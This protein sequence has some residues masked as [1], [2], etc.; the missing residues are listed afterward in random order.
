M[1]K[2][3]Q[4]LGAVAVSA[5]L[6]GCTNSGLIT[7]PTYSR[8]S[9]E[10]STPE[11][12]KEMGLGKVTNRDAKYTLER[13]VIGGEEYDVNKNAFAQGRELPFYMIRKQDSHI[14]LN[15]AGK[16]TTS[17]AEFM[18]IPKQVVVNGLPAHTA[19]FRTDGPYGIK[20]SLTDHK[21]KEVGVGLIR[22]TEKDIQFKIKVVKIN[23]E[24]WYLPQAPA[25]EE[26]DQNALPFYMIPVQG[27]TVDIA[28]A[29]GAVTLISSRGIFHPE[30]VTSEQYNTLKATILEARIEEEQR[31]KRERKR[32]EA[33]VEQQRQALLE[34]LPRKDN[35]GVIELI[36]N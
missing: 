16:T 3:T 18:Y 28:R 26:K 31:E 15:E 22:E 24:E 6:V 21:S 23:G 4:L 10:Y 25:R 27:T 32:M 11:S 19:K 30:K 13:L 2:L 7:D 17:T 20:A 34:N 35:P 5:G 12:Q 36:G 33:I 14:Q 9:S 8:K 1:S 29:D